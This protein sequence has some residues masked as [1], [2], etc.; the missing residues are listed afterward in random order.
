MLTIHKHKL[1]IHGLVSVQIHE[2]FVPLSVGLQQDEIVIWVSCTD[3][4]P[5]AYVQ[6]YCVFTGEDLNHLTGLNLNFIG[7]VQNVDGLVT[8]VFME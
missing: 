6:F 4:K 1:A 7:T 8:H 2:G 3:E 5:K